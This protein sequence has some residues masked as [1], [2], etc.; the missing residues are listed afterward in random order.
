MDREGIHAAV[1]LPTLASVIEERLEHKPE[2]IQAL[3]HSLN[4][5]VA[6][7]YGFGNGR[8][9]PV[10]AI[11]LSDVDVACKELDFLVEAGARAVLVRPAPVAGLRGSRSHGLPEF[12]PFWK[13]VEDAGI[14][15][16]H[17][18]SDSG[19]DRIYRRWT[20]GGKGEWRAFEKDPFGEMLDPIGRA[21]S[22]T[23]SALA[24]HGVFDRFPGVR[25]AVMESGSSW[26]ESLMK[27]FE[28]VYH[29]MP[30]AFA[31][32]PVESLRQH[33]F[34]APF[35]EEPVDKVVKLMGANRVL[36]GSDWPH[37]EGLGRPLDFF[38]DIAALPRDQQ[39]M[40][41]HDNLKGLLEGRRDDAM[42]R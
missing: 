23:L 13:R 9:Y 5:W 22:D 6:E 34:V 21:I 18:V 32:D 7:E 3:F 28:H 29:K 36:F 15:V 40:I 26:L 1:I 12:D 11:N 10:G 39:K 33:V 30:Q 37:P 25:I 41:M 24:C 8:Q 2:A 42:S 14:F 38:N 19:Y 4:L 35:Y 17:H 16:V 27:R 31:R 20:A